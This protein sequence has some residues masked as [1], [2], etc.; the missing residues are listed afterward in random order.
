MSWTQIEDGVEVTI[1]LPKGVSARD[2]SVTI[3]YN[4]IQFRLKNGYSMDEEGNEDTGGQKTL[5][6]R[7]LTGLN[8]YDNVDPDLSTWTLADGQLTIA[9]TKR[10]SLKWNDL[11]DK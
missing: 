10:E 6:Q 11:Y 7:L 1:D 2:I 8:L 4:L 9:L 5:L 3:K